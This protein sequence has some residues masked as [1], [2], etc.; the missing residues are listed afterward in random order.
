VIDEVSGEIAQVS[1]EIPQVSGA[2]A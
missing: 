2:V 1:R